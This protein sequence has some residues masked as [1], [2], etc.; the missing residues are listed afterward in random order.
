MV[1]EAPRLYR[2]VPLIVVTSIARQVGG[3]NSF[4]ALVLLTIAIVK[5][6]K[7]PL[8]RLSAKYNLLP[9]GAKTNEY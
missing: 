1:L 3:V 4:V 9:S 2:T 5:I 8:V 7:V 6:V